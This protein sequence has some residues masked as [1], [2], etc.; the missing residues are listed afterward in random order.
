MKR[1]SQL[2]FPSVPFQLLFIPAAIGV[3]DGHAQNVE[4]ILAGLVIDLGV[5]CSQ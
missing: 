2:V 1:I 3:V 4:V 5:G